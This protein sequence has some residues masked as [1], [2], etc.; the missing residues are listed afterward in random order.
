MG[1]NTG[2][3]NGSKD[4]SAYP[5]KNIAFV[6]A[7][8]VTSI[9][10]NLSAHKQLRFC[11]GFTYV[12][13]ISTIRNVTDISFSVYSL[14][15]ALIMHVY[16]MRSANPSIVEETK[17]KIKICMDALKD[18]SKVWLVAKMVHTLFDS[19]LGNKALEERLQKAS[20]KRHSKIVKQIPAKSEDPPKRKFDEMDFSAY[21]SGPPAPQVSYE[22][23]RP[24]SPAM[25]PRDLNNQPPGL[26]RQYNTNSPQI[27][28]NEP[29]LSTGASRN[30]TRP[31]TPFNQNG[32]GMGFVGAPSDLF[33]VTR[34]SPP[35][36]HNLWENFQPDHL[37]PEGST[38]N[39]FQQFSP[40]NM[41][42]T[43]GQSQHQQPP[44]MNSLGLGNTNDVQQQQQ[45]QQQRT[46]RAGSQT[47][48]LQSMAQ[49]PP[50]SAIQQLDAQ[51][52]QQQ[53]QPGWPNQFENVDGASP[54][55][56]WSN[57]S[58]GAPIPTT[59][60]VEDWYV[61]TLFHLLFC[62]PSKRFDQY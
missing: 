43:M 35:N 25:T 20:G 26:G 52:G 9:M 15:S 53:H 42:P 45:Q 7:S 1:P 16:Q 19:I 39:A 49:Q 40:Q 28:H 48:P 27:R 21:P 6:A 14:F 11:P 60:N 41:D 33:L 37:F 31:P 34:S 18:I 59:L 8:M 4:D 62:F 56:T 23:S 38:L 2:S 51:H 29:F 17:S 57:S 61:F 54:D 5:S 47:S 44:N 12:I 24:Q 22:R 50:Q 3:A 10:E 30:N 55:D 13:P 32:N 46:A 58:K 36:F